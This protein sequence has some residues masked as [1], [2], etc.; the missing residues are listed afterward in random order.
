MRAVLAIWLWADSL[1]R[2]SKPYGVIVEDMKGVW[3][4][5]APFS[6]PGLALPHRCLRPFQLTACCNEPL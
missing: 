1:G 5:D 3:Q 2:P 4:E 6:P